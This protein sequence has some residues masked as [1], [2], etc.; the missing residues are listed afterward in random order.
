MNNPYDVLVPKDINISQEELVQLYDQSFAVLAREFMAAHENFDALYQS[1]TSNIYVNEW[2]S[3]QIIDKEQLIDN[4]R[5]MILS[6]TNIIMMKY[7]FLDLK[8]STATF[9]SFA[10]TLYI[11]L[12]QDHYEVNTSQDEVEINKSYGEQL[13]EEEILQLVSTEIKRHEAYID[14]MKSIS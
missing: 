8:S 10:S 7:V 6:N 5:K 14:E 4:A 3:T 11:Y 1:Q 9:S 13:S 12:E 2:S